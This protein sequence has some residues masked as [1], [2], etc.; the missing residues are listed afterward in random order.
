M[1]PKVDI[2]QGDFDPSFEVN[3]GSS[4]LAWGFFLLI[5]AAV[6]IYFYLKK[7]NEPEPDEHT[8]PV[9]DPKEVDPSQKSAAGSSEE[10]TGLTDQVLDKVQ[11]K[12][13]DEK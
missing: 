7:K 11:G 4:P 9:P 2:E 1:A 10:G 8:E 3:A 5:I 13:T 6:A 12:G